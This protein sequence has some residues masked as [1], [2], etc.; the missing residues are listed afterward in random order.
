MFGGLMARVMTTYVSYRYAWSC[1]FFT[2]RGRSEPVAIEA[3]RSRVLRGLPY[4]LLSLLLGWWGF[5]WGP[6]RTLEALAVNFGGGEDVTREMNKK[7]YG[8]EEPD[9]KWDC[10]QCKKLNPNTSYRCSCG[11]SL[12]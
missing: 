10:P 7:I 8:V 2:V 6:I 9:A 4:S 11:Y 12:V 1:I 3:G 5:P